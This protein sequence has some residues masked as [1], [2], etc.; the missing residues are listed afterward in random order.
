MIDF[1]EFK[2]FFIFAFIGG[3]IVSALTAVVTVLIGH[4]DEVTAR[5]FWTLFMVIVHSLISLAFIW[6]D[7]RRNTFTKLAFFV[8]TVFVLVILSFFTSVFGVWKIISY[9]T[10]WH[11]YQTYFL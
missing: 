7:S 6:D 2:K 10:A 9:E 4:F 8:N 1:K 3:L 5:V 11:F